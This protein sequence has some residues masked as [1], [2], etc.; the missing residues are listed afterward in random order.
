VDG[1]VDLLAAHLGEIGVLRNERERGAIL[2]DG[3]AASRQFDVAR[4]T[5]SDPC[6]F[7]HRS[8]DL[9]EFSLK[10]PAVCAFLK[11]LIALFRVFKRA[12]INAMKI[13]FDVTF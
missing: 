7:D 13:M 3:Q 6:P 5:A 11:A 4:M 10:P 8:I 12:Q 2:D 1:N 9:V